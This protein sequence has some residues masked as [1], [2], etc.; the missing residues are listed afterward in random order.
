MAR[1]FARGASPRRR[2]ATIK[3]LPGILSGHQRRHDSSLQNEAEQMI[4][5]LAFAAGKRRV[6]GKALVHAV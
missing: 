6:Q 4:R 1:S 2:D 5:C 3:C